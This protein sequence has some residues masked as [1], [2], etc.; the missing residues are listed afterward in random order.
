MCEAARE[1]Y[2]P[3]PTYV[4]NVLV[5][6]E[7]YL[8]YKATCRVIPRIVSDVHAHVFSREDSTPGQSVPL[9]ATTPTDPPFVAGAP[10]GFNVPVRRQSSAVATRNHTGHETPTYIF[11]WRKANETNGDNSESHPRTLINSGPRHRA[12]E[13]Q[14]EGFTASSMGTA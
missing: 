2:L 8:L 1:Q 3:A 13:S 11:Q 4:R 14:A 5:L 9:A 6:C 12:G 7:S 10:T